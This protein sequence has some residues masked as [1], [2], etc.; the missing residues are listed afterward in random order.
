MA[1]EIKRKHGRPKLIDN[2][3]PSPIPAGKDVNDRKN[4]DDAEEEQNKMLLGIATQE[5]LKW[6]KQ[7]SFEMR[8]DRAINMI[9]ARKARMSMRE[10]A[11]WERQKQQK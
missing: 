3:T 4:V 11:F 1:E 9:A 8:R 6:F 7:K 10:K 2:Y 5:D